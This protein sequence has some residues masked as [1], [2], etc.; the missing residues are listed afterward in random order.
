MPEVW[1]L[2]FWGIIIWSHFWGAKRALVCQSGRWLHL[3]QL[4]WG[5]AGWDVHHKSPLL[6]PV[7]ASANGGLLS[8]RTDILVIYYEMFC[9]VEW[10]IT[11]EITVIPCSLMIWK[12]AKELKQLD[13]SYLSS[14]KSLKWLNFWKDIVSKLAQ[15]G[16]WACS[17]LTTVFLT[18]SLLLPITSNTFDLLYRFISIYVASCFP[19]WITS[20]VSNFI[21][22]LIEWHIY[23][24]REHCWVCLCGQY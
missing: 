9:Y 7:R 5:S 20:A 16:F 10:W 12:S 14:R 17:A 4:C 23:S 11:T 6:H 21:C 3:L 24:F 19:G 13:A 22:R 18:L 15:C 2:F 1:S 8:M